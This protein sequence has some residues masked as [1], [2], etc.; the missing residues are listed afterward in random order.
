L[1]QKQLAPGFTEGVHLTEDFC[2]GKERQFL[3]ESEAE[4][5]DLNRGLPTFTRVMVKEKNQ[6]GFGLGFK[7]FRP[8]FKG[9]LGPLH[10]RPFL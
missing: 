4:E 8:W 7:S 5:W 9:S 6:C 2:G 10:E 3:F 1:I